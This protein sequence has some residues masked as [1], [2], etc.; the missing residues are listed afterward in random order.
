MLHAVL[1][2][3]GQTP[4]SLSRQKRPNILCKRSWHEHWVGG[5]EATA[6][7]PN[8]CLRSTS[9]S[10]PAPSPV[11]LRV[12][13][14]QRMAPLLG[15][16]LVLAGLLVEGEDLWGPGSCPWPS[17]SGF[18]EYTWHCGPIRTRVLSKPYRAA[19]PGVLQGPQNPFCL[20]SSPPQGPQ[21]L[22][23]A[24]GT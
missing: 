13:C 19:V 24:M 11:R 7:P 5:W 20:R 4:P 15:L 8:H 17:G 21:A 2:D 12:T 23:P 1:C 18:P 22:Q 3:P 14:T 9:P 16:R 6:C 10:A